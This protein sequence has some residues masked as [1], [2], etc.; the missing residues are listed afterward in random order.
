MTAIPYC[1]YCFFFPFSYS[2]ICIHC[3]D[4]YLK[5]VTFLYIYFFV[6]L[7]IVFCEKHFFAYLYGLVVDV[8]SFLS[9]LIN[10]LCKM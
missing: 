1:Y 6:V 7:N 3:I 2:S 9:H 4:I 8:A 10:F 5:C